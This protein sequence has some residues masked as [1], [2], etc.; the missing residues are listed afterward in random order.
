[1]AAG[2]DADEVYELMLEIL[3]SYAKASGACAIASAPAHGQRILDAGYWILDTDD[4][5]R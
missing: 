3:A 2:A 4:E 5:I 1:L